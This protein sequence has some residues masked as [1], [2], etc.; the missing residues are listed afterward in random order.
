MHRSPALIVLALT[1]AVLAAVLAAAPAQSD[2]PEIRLNTDTTTELQN[3]EQ[4]AVNPTDP[5][6]VVACWRDFRL[7]YRQVGV[8]TSFD[9]GTTWTDRLIGGQLP[10]D[11]DP[12][13]AVHRDGTFYLVVINYQNGGANQ[14][15]VHR[16]TTGGVSWEG[17]FQ[18]VY[19]AGDTFE[20]KEMIAVD[21]TG[22]VRDGYVYIAWSR[23]YETRI[24]CVR[25]GNRGVTWNSPVPVSDAGRSCQWPVPIVAA[26][27][28]LLVAWCD[29]NTP[30]I[31]YD[32]STNGGT[33]WGTDRT[34][35]TAT[36]G[37]GQIINGGILVFPYPSLVLDETP[38]P[39]AGWVYCVYPDAAVAGNGM[40][41]W[42]RRSTDGG[43]TWGARV[44]VNDDLQGLVRD[45]FHPWVACDEGGIL[46]ATWYD[47]RDDPG[48]YLWHIYYSSSSDG[49][50]T[51]D[52]SMRVTTV[53]SSPG[54]A[55]GLAAPVGREPLA[56]MR[57]GLI[58]E[59]SGVAAAQGV[60]H[61]IWTDTRNGNQDVYASVIVTTTGVSDPASRLA[62]ASPSSPRI[63]LR[64]VPNPAR[65][66]GSELRLGVREAIDAVLEVRGPT[67]RLVRRITA[68]RL[69]AGETAVGWDGR[70]ESGRDLPSGV[71]F[72][73]LTGGGRTLAG[74]RFVLAR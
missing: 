60:V 73:R 55:K 62:A 39:R 12:A 3:E 58:G 33:S 48:N 42:C 59:Y 32:I 52:V 21:R 71:Y 36:T 53:A 26:G 47:R 20:D 24:M 46:H 15:S 63:Q 57:A 1:A 67:G 13:L 29:L 51:W 16:S 64:M 18:A 68:G 34:L 2:L 50:G 72:L 44:R 30:R 65:G 14:L 43:N 5:N 37:A 27:G 38:G 8:G 22:G 19:S 9:G 49:G 54:D 10:W 74:E 7:G 17:P 69:P 45:Q 35:T 6:N 66:A 41:I 28:S 25:S 56:L 70:D 40:D 11:S 61:P 23:F 4:I 31:L